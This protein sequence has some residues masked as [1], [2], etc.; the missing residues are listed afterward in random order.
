MFR[1]DK[2]A[3]A[4]PDGAATR[5]VATGS[6]V[7]TVGDPSAGR[8]AFDIFPSRF[9]SRLDSAIMV[10]TP[11]STGGI[12]LAYSASRVDFKDRKIDIE[13]FGLVLHSSGPDASGVFLHH[14]D[15]EGRTQPPPASFWD[16]MSESRICDYFYSNPPEGLRDGGIEQL[17][18][19][20]RGAF[21]AIIRTIRIR[22]DGL[23]K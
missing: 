18:L 20:H 17:P 21:D 4:N 14:G 15:W 9:R 7:V 8:V 16:A 1:H 2:T 3:L 13:P 5:R 23:K 6:S 11:T 10:S 19:G 22:L 12:Y